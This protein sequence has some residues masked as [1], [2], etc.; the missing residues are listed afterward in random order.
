MNDKPDD[1][2]GLIVVAVGLGAIAILVEIGSAI[3]YSHSTNASFD[4]FIAQ[5]PFDVLSVAVWYAA[6]TWLAHHIRSLIGVIGL[7]YGLAIAGLV[8]VLAEGEPL[9]GA[10][11]QAALG[12][13]ILAVFVSVMLQF[14]DGGG[15][16][17]NW[18]HTGEAILLLVA[19]AGVATYLEFTESQ[20]W[21]FSF[22]ALILAAGAALIVGRL[23]NQH[24]LRSG[25]LGALAAAGAAKEVVEEQRA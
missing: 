14:F 8:S 21:Q 1:T 15:G 24:G 7:S 23:I 4:G 19:V 22:A 13:T 11:G 12:G 10:A 20:F 9:F 18:A 3:G 2:P 6:G 5:H 25:P 16:P 17:P